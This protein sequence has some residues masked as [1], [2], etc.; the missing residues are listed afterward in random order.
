MCTRNRFQ[1]QIEDRVKTLA[2][3]LDYDADPYTAIEHGKMYWVID[4]YTSSGYYPY[5]ESVRTGGAKNAAQTNPRNIL[6][7]V[8]GEQLTDQVNYVRNPVKVVV[9]AYNGDVSFYVF[10]PEDHIIRAWENTSPGMLKQRSEMEDELEKQ[11]RYPADLILRQGL[12]YS[13]FHMTN[14]SVFY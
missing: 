8:N 1:R 11:I 14:T 10:D 7:Y 4:A 12:G 5:S 6:Q 3:F 9:D 13:K 2:P